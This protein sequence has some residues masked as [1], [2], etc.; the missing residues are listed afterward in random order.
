LL[1]IVFDH[2]NLGTAKLNDTTLKDV[3]FKHCNLMGVDFG[4]VNKILLSLSFEGCRLDLS[5][6]YKLKLK[7]TRFSKCSIKEADFTETDLSKSVFAECDLDGAIFERS[8]LE[9]VD[10]TSSDNYSID[11]ENNRLKKAKFSRSGL[12]GLLGKHDIVI[13]I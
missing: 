13:E 11:P 9:K 12:H 4:E 6:F 2:C 5:S 7:A 10:F 3:E 1:E 8:N